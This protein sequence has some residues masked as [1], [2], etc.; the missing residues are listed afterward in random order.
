[1]AL[2]GKKQKKENP[3]LNAYNNK[4]SEGAPVDAE[5]IV[6]NAEPASATKVFG[7][8]KKTLLQEENDLL[9]A[10]VDELSSLMTPELQDLQRIKQ[11][12]E[13]FHTLALEEQNKLSSLKEK[14]RIQEKRLES[15][16]N[17]I[18]VA[19]ESIE[20]ESF[21]IYK[22]RWEF[23]K[24][25]DYKNK[26]RQITDSQKAM[27]KNGTAA[28]GNMSWTVNNS[29]AK[30]QKLVRDMMKLCLRSFN[31]ECDAAVSAVRF[32]NYDR[33]ENRIYKS[34]DS[35]SKLGA[36]MN[37]GI[38][39]TY[40]NLKIKELQ[41]ALEYQIKK[42]EEKDRLRELK[43]QEREEA[44]A[45]KE[46]EAARK[47]AEKEQAHYSNA[48]S[49]IDTKL[50]IAKD[51]AEKSLL[52]EKRAEIESHL[53]KVAESIK[54]LDYR[55]S[56]QRAGYVYIISNIG[57][58]GENVYKIG[59][60]RRLDP[61]E[62][63]DE[64]GDASVPFRFDVHAMIFSDDAPALEAALH[65]EFENKK[66][67]M[68]NNRKEFFNVTLDEIKTVVHKNHD[69]VVEFTDIAPAD[70]YRESLKMKR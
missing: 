40:I 25:E 43:A 29:N 57:A 37:V 48:L 47:A 18:I 7:K 35:V 65:K 4:Y 13:R 24:A 22:P 17:D 46:M 62:R 50:A 26:L 68:V 59:M 27:I 39:R 1:M 60:T 3:Y 8:S 23:A 30:G 64:L 41:L 12:T 5:F 58:F 70:Q 21:S 14:T 2:F 6:E 63:V 10:K 32:N 69:K 34:V 51:E 15:L 54:D 9:K 28:Y 61:Q 36:M 52:L 44:K 55:Y 11:E 66:V 42:Q 67:N 19:E 56:N 53:I 38:S 49:Q 33:C 16:Q 45:L 20:L 31:N